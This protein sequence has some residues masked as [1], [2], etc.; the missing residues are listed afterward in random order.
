MTTLYSALW[1][2]Q[3]RQPRAAVDQQND[4]PIAHAYG[5]RAQQLQQQRLIR[6]TVG[7]SDTLS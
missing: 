7:T 1:V 3:L 4:E 2:V 5:I 6:P